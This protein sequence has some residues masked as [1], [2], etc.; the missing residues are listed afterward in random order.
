MN[1]LSAYR[2]LVYC[3]VVTSLLACDGSS[4]ESN[5]ADNL[6]HIYTYQQLPLP[7]GQ[8]DPAA[9]VNYSQTCTLQELPFIAFSYPSPKISDVMSR[10]VVS[11]QWMGERFESLL[12][13]LPPEIIDLM[14]SVTAIVI[15]DNIRPSFYWKNT[16]AIYLDPQNLWLSNEEKH[17]ISQEDDYRSNYGDDLAYRFF[18]R[19]IKDNQYAYSYYPLDGDQERTMDDIIAPMASLLFHELAHANDFMPQPLIPYIALNQTPYSAVYSV[20]SQWANKKLTDFSPLQ[21]DELFA[22]AQI[23]YK[24]NQATEQQK[25]DSAADMGELIQLQGANHFYAYSTHAED[26][27]MLFQATML[28]KTLDIDMDSAFVVKPEGINL[29]CSDYIVAWGERNRIANIITKPRARLVSELMQPDT[30]FND[31]FDNL[32]SPEPF[33]AETDWCTTNLTSNLITKSKLK[34]QNKMA[35]IKHSHQN[36]STLSISGL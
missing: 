2:T 18:H 4:S 34:S 35:N 10:V 14:G 28:K 24:G 15:A 30:D 32:A 26:V 31:F 12:T 13:E 21:G 22:H 29:N 8:Q 36:G 17:S 6:D 33:P 19:I 3:L 1:R 20:S 23:M 27:A 25:Q 16:A 9:C 11:H 5:N 7:E